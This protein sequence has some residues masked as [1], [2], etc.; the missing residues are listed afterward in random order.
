MQNLRHFL[1]E[2]AKT[3]ASSLLREPARW[4]AYLIIFL[5][6][7]ELGRHF[8][9]PSA[10]VYGIR[11]DYLSPTV[12]LLDILVIA[13]LIIRRSDLCEA[14][15]RPY[16]YLIPVLIL[17]LFYSQNPLST[18]TW[19]LH[20]LLYG[21]FVLS[22][23]F[24]TLRERVFGTFVIIAAMFFQVA[25]GLAQILNGHSL[26]GIFYW[27]GERAVSVGQ[28]GIAVASF[29]GK[30]MLRAYGTFGHPNALAGWLVIACLIVIQLSQTGIPKA[31]K[32]RAER[33]VLCVTMSL[34]ILGVLLT[35]SRAAAISLL[36][37]VIPFWLVKKTRFRTLYL[38]LIL[39]ACYLLL[40]TGL[41]SRDFDLSL[42]D[43]LNLQGVSLSVIRAY[44]IFGS[45]A[46][47]SI[48]TYPVVTPNIRL[49]QP[50]HDSFTL[51]LSWFGI[52]GVIAFVYSLKSK[53][54]NLKSLFRLF[55]LLPL[56]TLDHYLL[57]SPQGLF[58]LLLYFQIVCRT[59]P[60]PT[61]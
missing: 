35:D 26:Q 8:W 36:C 3:A 19:S 37:I 56:L 14:K 47:A 49:L 13:Y 34:A 31:R 1:R 11:V 20:L 51:L 32:Q 30:T 12:Y 52:I 22:L 6:S 61:D 53:I 45:G 39:V 54:L 46:S 57:T 2:K 41:I 60:R 48:S 25:L 7:S 42:S 18:L 59:N 17:N 33:C 24:R 55:P 58:I 16:G 50:D 43:R 21:A 10:L 29:F 23:E 5:A 4:L 15:V 28:P 27:L 40:T 44:P 38:A 9:P